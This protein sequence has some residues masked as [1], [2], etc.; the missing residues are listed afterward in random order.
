MTNK[1]NPEDADKKK[2]IYIIFISNYLMK[3]D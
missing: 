3:S 1:K 2:Y